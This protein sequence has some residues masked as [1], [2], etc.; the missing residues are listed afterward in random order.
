MP[1]AR[2]GGIRTGVIGGY[3]AGCSAVPSA[4]GMDGRAEGAAVLTEAS[5]VISLGPILQGRHQTV[6]APLKRR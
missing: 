4:A 5:N 3:G 6:L 2:E 1:E